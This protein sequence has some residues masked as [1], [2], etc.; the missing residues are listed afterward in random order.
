M[1]KRI[2]N[3]EK[4]MSALLITRNDTEASEL[5]GVS[6]RSISRAKQNTE[7]ME[8]FN[9]RRTEIIDNTCKLLQSQIQSAVLTA[10]DIM[11]NE[12]NSDQV[13]LNACDLII[14]NTY[15]LT[16]LT[17]TKVKLAKLQERLNEL[18]IIDS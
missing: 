17:D 16:E 4:I 8:E 9:Q 6:T 15:R 7:F 11:N 13:R 2:N 5:S 10:V 14:R 1:A 3:R 18:N 12:S